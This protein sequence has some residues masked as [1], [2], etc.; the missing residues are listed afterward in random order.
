M[1]EEWESDPAWDNLHVAAKRRH[2]DEDKTQINSEIAQHLVEESVFKFVKMHLLNHFPEDIRQLGNLLN[3]SSELTEK[4]MMDFKHAY[5]QSNRH[6]ASFQMLQT[7]A[8]KK[9]F[10]YRQL[11]A[12]AAKSRGDDYMPLTNVPIKRIMKYPRPETKTLDDSAQ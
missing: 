12:K 9:V 3:V 5:Q 8:Q 4:A 6:E 10:Q 7:Q 11:N 1:Q 2:L